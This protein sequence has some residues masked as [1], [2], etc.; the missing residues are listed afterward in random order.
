[1]GRET[2]P[3]PNDPVQHGANG[4]AAQTAADR[5]GDSDVARACASIEAKAG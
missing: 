5:E 2:T 3:A 4:A 1:M